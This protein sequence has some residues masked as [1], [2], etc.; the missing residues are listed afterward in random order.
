M[1]I[2]TLKKN[3]K[4]L[5]SNAWDSKKWLDKIEQ[6][7]ED[8]IRLFKSKNVIKIN[9][10][11]AESPLPILLL[12]NKKKLKILDFGAGSLEMPLKIAFDTNIKSNI[13]IDIIESKQ[14]II[15]YEKIFKKI[16]LPKNISIN[17]SEKINFKKKYDIFHFSDSFQYVDKWKLF[18]KRVIKNSPN[19]IIFNNLTAGENPT[20][21]AVQ[22]FY[23][24]DVLYRFYNIKQ[25]V[26]ELCPYQ[27]I[28]KSKFLNKI[29]NRY[30]EYPQ[31]NFKKNYRLGYPCTLIFKK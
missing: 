9:T 11:C 13:Q 16:K 7:I 25:F 15:L 26:R 5:Q 19:F 2:W 8:N 22:K 4:N 10:F 28:Y 6:R 21:E 18:I 17:L 24:H 23:K 31:N 1:N 14:L 12:N 30:S 20:Y 27:L 29:L 3:N